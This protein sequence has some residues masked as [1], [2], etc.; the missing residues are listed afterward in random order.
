MRLGH[1]AANNPERLLD[2]AL[3]ALSSDPDWRTALDA[4]PVPIYTTDAQGAVTYWNLACIE[5]A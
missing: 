4:L 5:L 2:E 3:R 1:L